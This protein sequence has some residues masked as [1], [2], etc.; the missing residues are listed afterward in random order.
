VSVSA[1]T[2]AIAVTAVAIVMSL[3]APASARPGRVGPSYVTKSTPHSMTVRW[4]GKADATRYEARI[5]RSP[6]AA[7][8]GATRLRSHG[9]TV[10]FEHLR[11]RTK[12]CFT[13]RALR[14]RKP[15]PLSA[16]TCHLTPARPLVRSHPKVSV[17]T[18][19]V[20]AIAPHCGR[21]KPREKAIVRQILD[22][23]ADVVALQE[24]T[25][26]ADDLARRLRRH[27]YALHTPTTSG[28][29]EAIFYRTDK[30]A[31]T[32]PAMTSSACDPA[33][34]PICDTPAP[35]ADRYG[36]IWTRH[37]ATA[38][39]AEL[40]LLSTGTT[41][42][43]VSTHLTHADTRFSAARRHTETRRIVA[44]ARRIAGGSTIVFMGDF[45]SY[46]G[47][48]RDSPRVEMARQ[49]WYDAY[50][51]SATYSHPYIT[52][53]NG[54]R[55]TITTLPY[56]GGHI[57]RIFID[58]SVG[59]THWRVVART[60]KG[61]YVGTRASDHNPVRATLYLP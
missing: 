17:A 19:N 61:R 10:T 21:W 40:R 38:A 4:P 27:G 16:V 32:V 33:V 13:V 2:F 45:N 42:V 9:T 25:R 11:A 5:G 36:K 54:Y 53:Y 1:R 35:V 31:A 58:R 15:G 34:E 29:D 41:Y 18:F 6:A 56:W 28:L 43:F 47:L 39:W 49:G 57:D 50:D 52:S 48:R 30:L 37:G 14:G 12:Y 55:K 8:R 22:A 7:R 24:V 3:A 51:G 46:R 26:R 59:S 60:R 23:D 44:A 20:C